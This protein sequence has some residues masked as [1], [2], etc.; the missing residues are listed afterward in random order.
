[1]GSAKLRF[2]LVRKFLRV[3]LVGV[4]FSLSLPPIPICALNLT[5]ST[6]L[7]EGKEVGSGGKTSQQL[8]VVP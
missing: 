8:I 7:G 4:T 5:A 2:S 1:M 6:E 3:Q